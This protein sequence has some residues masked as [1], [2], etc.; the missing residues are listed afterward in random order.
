MTGPQGR[1]AFGGGLVWALI[2]VIVVPIAVFILG[3]VLTSFNPRCGG[4]GD[5]DGCAMGV[6]GNAFEAALPGAAIGFTYGLVR[7]WR[8]TKK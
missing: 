1:A 4:P 6:F 3:L 7:A 8:R 2:A 5:S